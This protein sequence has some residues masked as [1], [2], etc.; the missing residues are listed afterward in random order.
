METR[1]SSSCDLTL[2]RSLP[3][4]A[5]RLQVLIQAND[6]LAVLVA[7]VRERFWMNTARE[8]LQ[9]LHD[10]RPRSIEIGVAVGHVDASFRL[11]PG[12]PGQ[13]RSEHIELVEGALQR[14][15][16]GLDQHD[17]WLE[18]EQGFFRHGRRVITGAGYQ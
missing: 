4:E 11:A 5:G 10:P 14:K 9:R 8:D 13:R 17:V 16:A 7:K 12:V 18:R 3:L 2:L 6:R 15:A 1:L